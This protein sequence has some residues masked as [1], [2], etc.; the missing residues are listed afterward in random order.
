MKCRVSGSQIQR[1]KMMDLAKQI[2][3]LLHEYHEHLDLNV[4]QDDESWPFL[5]E[6]CK[7][8]SN[9]ALFHLW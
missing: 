2:L 1:E 9:T 5:D 8:A 7:L 4:L 3:C 6:T